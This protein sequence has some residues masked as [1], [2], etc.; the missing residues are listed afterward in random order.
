MIGGTLQSIG[1]V[2]ASATFVNEEVVQ[3]STIIKIIRII[4]IVIV[5]YVLIDSKCGFLII[6]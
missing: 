6:N 2:V 4:F 3:L 1:Q 5:V